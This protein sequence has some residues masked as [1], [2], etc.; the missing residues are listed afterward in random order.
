[1][2][3]LILLQQWRSDLLR[4]VLG[5]LILNGELDLAPAPVTANA[6]KCA[7]EH[8]QNV[9]VADAALHEEGSSSV[10]EMERV[11]SAQRELE[12]KYEILVAEKN[13]L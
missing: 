11:L 1:M 2:P 10:P 13:T 4:G 12:L 5:Q 7:E 9:Y 6:D 8:Y 3:V